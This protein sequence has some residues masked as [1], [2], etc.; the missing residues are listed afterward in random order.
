MKDRTLDSPCNVG[1][2]CAS[3]T[4]NGICGVVAME[5][6]TF[7][8]GSQ[9]VGDKV[10]IRKPGARLWQL[11]RN[12]GGVLDDTE[13]L[14]PPEHPFATPVIP[15]TCDDA[16]QPDVT[17]LEAAC[18]FPVAFPVCDQARP[19]RAI[20]N[21]DCAFD[22]VPGNGKGDPRREARAAGERRA[23]SP[24]GRVRVLQRG[25]SRGGATPVPPAVLLPS[26]S[27]PGA[28]A[29]RGADCGDPGS[30]CRG[31]GARRDEHRPGRG[32][33]RRRPPCARPRQ[34]VDRSVWSA[35]IHTG[36]GTTR[37]LLLPCGR[38]PA[39]RDGGIGGQTKLPAACVLPSPARGARLG[40]SATPPRV[41]QCCLPSALSA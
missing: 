27:P 11:F 7:G 15:G 6:A 25:G 31:R 38:S 17:M 22:S 37:T 5:D 18:G 1:G 41:A 16:C 29:P 34:H 3:V 26:G 32:L 24:G 33:M 2:H 10:F 30:R 9:V 35:C 14:A 4:T 19:V 8:T 36:L 12:D 40:T 28:T 21:A 13:L 39:R 23:P 20:P